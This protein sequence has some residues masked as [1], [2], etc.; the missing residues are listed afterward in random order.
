MKLSQLAIA[1]LKTWCKCFWQLRGTQL[2]RKLER[3]GFVDA[4]S[5]GYGAVW[6]RAA[7]NALSEQHLRA[8]VRIAPC[9]RHCS[10]I[11]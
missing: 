11:G 10:A 8:E 6:A 7:A 4:S 9:H 2:R 5:A 3:I 1:E